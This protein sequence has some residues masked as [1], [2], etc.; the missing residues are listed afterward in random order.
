[1]E[2]KTKMILAVVIVAI[3][4]VGASLFI[5]FQENPDK[6]K[7]IGTWEWRME[8]PESILKTTIIRFTFYENDTACYNITFCYENSNTTSERWYSYNIQGDK[9]CCEALYSGYSELGCSNYRFSENY[10]SLTLYDVGDPDGGT[11]YEK[12]F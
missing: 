11:T 12:I 5:V 9:L 3:A 1:M 6:S 2:K 10:T 7:F 4:V 8:M